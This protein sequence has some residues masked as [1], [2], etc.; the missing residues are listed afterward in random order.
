M[1]IGKAPSIFRI[2]ALIC[3]VRRRI[4]AELTWIDWPASD[5]P[6]AEGFEPVSLRI[7]AGR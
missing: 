5:W 7:V 4:D 2:W 6:G 3:P 1:F